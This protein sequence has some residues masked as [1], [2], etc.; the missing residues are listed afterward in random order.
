M[1]TSYFNLLKYAATGIASPDMTY[2]DKMRASTLMGGAVQTLTGQPPLT[3]KADGTPLIS[4]SMKGNGQQTGTPSPDNIIMPELVGVRTAN[5]FDIS[6]VKTGKF[7]RAG[8]IS[9][10]RPLG[11]EVINA[12]Y[13][14]SDYIAVS[15]ETQYTVKYPS[16]YDAVGAGLV[17]FDTSK[18]AISSVSLHEQGG[19]TYSFTTPANCAYVRLSWYNIN[20]DACMLN[21]GSTALPYEPFGWAEK[22]TCA[23]QTTPIYL[24]E[25]PTVRRIRKLV[26]TGTEPET[27]LKMPVANVFYVKTEK[28]YSYESGKCMCT[29]YVNHQVVNSEMTSGEIKQDTTSSFGQQAG[30]IVIKD[31]SYSSLANFKSFLAAQYAAGTPV[32]VWYVLANEQTGIVNEPLCKIGTY[33]DELH[34]EDA[35]VSIPT[36]KGQNVLTVETELQ[37]SEMTI[38]YKG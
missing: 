18:N 9:E 19:D 14:C 38:T 8:N 34:S 4:W 37:P 2:Y 33:A 13:D 16:F 7:V 30:V 31:T 17:Y 21:L 27:E 29:H 36:A 25:V 6:S 12:G 22:I 11:E 23:G 3:F 24:G 32:T 20:G 26:L 15:A 35:G 28:Q 10:S 5:L 1:M